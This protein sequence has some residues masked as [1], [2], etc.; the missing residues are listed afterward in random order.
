MNSTRIGVVI[1]AGVLFGLAIVVAC[2]GGSSGGGNR[3]VSG[4]FETTHWL[5]DGSK[6]TVREP[7]LGKAVL[8]ALLVPDGSATGYTVKAAL[9]DANQAFSVKDVPAG[10]YFVQLDN[11]VY[12]CCSGGLMV[13]A[14]ETTLI[15]QAADT[16]DF[17]RVT[18]SRADLTMYDYGPLPAFNISGLDPWAAGD[19]IQIASAQGKSYAG[20]RLSPSPAE[21]TT[22]YD[23]AQ[24]DF[25]EG[26]PNA[27]KGDSVYVYQRSIR[28]IGS[29]GTAAMVQVPTRY[30]RKTDLTVVVGGPPIDVALAQ[31][32]QTGSVRVAARFSQFAALRAQVHPG[33]V[34]ST[35]LP[36]VA[37]IAVPRSVT[38]PEM[39]FKNEST[40]LLVLLPPAGIATDVDYGAIQYGEFL[41]SSWRAF[42]FASYFYDVDVPMPAGGVSSA[43][44]VTGIISSRIA[45]SPDSTAMTP[46]VGPP[47]EPR[48]EDRDAFVGQSGVGLQPTISW[49]PPTLGSATS[50]QISITRM[51]E[52]AEGEVHQLTV[53][54]YSGTRFRIPPGL[55]KT[56]ALYSTVITARSA[57]WDAGDHAPFRTGVPLHT[58]DC[59]LGMFVP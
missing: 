10:P 53:T 59:V 51:S 18:A 7:P 12:P 23:G 24:W 27:S 22:A 21:G 41:D 25:T 52:P 33:A 43:P 3:T 55:L 48:I 17:G 15:E 26:L 35:L 37:V 50:Y 5:D 44:S 20:L 42:L 32:P 54:L 46:A 58:A 29:G 36:G 13:Q 57:P 31:A 19:R 45:L 16:P 11:P 38:F 56:G 40:G 2:D 9:T 47:T 8:K 1:A 6:T 30:A 4:A 49:S 14:V 34:A 39:P 28:T